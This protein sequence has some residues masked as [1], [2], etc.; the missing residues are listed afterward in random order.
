MKLFSRSPKGQFISYYSVVS[1]WLPA[2]LDATGWMQRTGVLSDAVDALAAWCDGRAAKDFKDAAVRASANKH[3]YART[4]SSQAELWLKRAEL[5]R[6]CGIKLE[7][8]R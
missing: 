1:E 4:K 8:I 6:E 7:A 3:I 5:I 2:V